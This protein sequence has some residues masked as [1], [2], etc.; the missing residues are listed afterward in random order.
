MIKNN[1]KVCRKEIGLT[2]TELG[3]IFNIKKA[4]ISNWEN[5]Y[6]IIPLS[7]LIKFCN[8][9]NFSVDY[10]L[11]LKDKNHKHSNP[12]NN[13]KIKI[14]E[15]LKELRKELKL[16]QEK[17]A[18]ECNISRATYCHYE[19]GMNLISTSSLYT[20]CK[21]HKLSIDEFLRK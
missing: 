9:Y 18:S 7:N 13:D 19:I 4:T 8:L 2:Q 20:I 3:N 16:S 10:V 11:G 12:I 15:K 1:L 14:G 17:I 6:D 21:N 5:G